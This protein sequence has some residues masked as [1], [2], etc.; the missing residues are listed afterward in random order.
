MLLAAPLVAALLPAAPITCPDQTTLANLI[1][2][3]GSGGCQIQDKIFSN[4]T[5]SGST[6]ASD[7]GATLVFRPGASSDIHGWV[8]AP[9]GGT[10]VANF[11]LAYTITVAPGSTGNVSIVAGKDQMNSGFLPN[12]VTV[13]DV[14]TPG[15][16][17]PVTLNLAGNLGSETAQTTYSSPVSTVG[18]SSTATIPS[19]NEIQSYEQDF[20]ESLTVPEPPSLIYGLLGGGFMLFGLLRVRRKA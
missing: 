12:G 4:F 8:F 7:V 9:V 6:A 1:T 2:L 15:G 11:M 14:Q 18:T 20:L 3:S 13:Q 19:G 17:P 10:W 5:Y 16:Q